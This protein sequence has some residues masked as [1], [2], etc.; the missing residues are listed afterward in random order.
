MD[1]F[2]FQT[3]NSLAGK[4][5][6]LDYLGIF[7]AEYLIFVMAIIVFVPLVIRIGNKKI[8]LIKIILAE[9]AGYS[10]KTIIQLIYFR[11]RPFMA[12][13]VIKLVDKSPSASFPSGH[14]LV[15][16]ILAFSV[17]F[18]NKK[19]GTYF[20][21]LAFLVGLGRIYA[22]IHYPFDVVTSI[23]IAFFVVYLIWKIPWQK[24]INE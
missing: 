7:C 19:L 21:F 24:I 11:P 18:Y 9:I 17:Y 23:F 3:I 12:H 16:F 1:F 15:A 2:I 10:L 22:G 5:K 6:I 14:T 13:E 4:W 8:N 20:I